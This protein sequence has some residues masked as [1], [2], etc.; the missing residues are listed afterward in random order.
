MTKDESKSWREEYKE[1][2][3]LNK[4]QI[5]LLE[6]G[7]D[8][9]ASSWLLQSMHNDWKKIKGIKEPEPPNCQSSFKEWNKST[10]DQ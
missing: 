7:P 2:K 5:Y 4:R 9:L 3:V 8:S 6:N 1:M 10:E